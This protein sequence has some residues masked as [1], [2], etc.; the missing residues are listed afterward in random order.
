[1]P[2]M[3]PKPGINHNDIA[4]ISVSSGSIA[5]GRDGAEVF[6]SQQAPVSK[7]SAPQSLDELYAKIVNGLNGEQKQKVEAPLGS[8]RAEIEKGEDGD[9][10]EVQ[11]ALEKIR[12]GLGETWPN[13]RGEL[14][15]LIE[16]HSNAS[17]PIKIIARKLLS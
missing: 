5:V 3:I 13:L 8:V 11:R 9:V 10:L 1:M 16:D 15:K 7:A 6:I 17:L 14:W 12:A 2:V 4:K